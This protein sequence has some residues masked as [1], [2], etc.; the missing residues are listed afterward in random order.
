[1]TERLVSIDIA[2]AICIILVVIGHYIPDIS[3]DWYVVMLDLIYAFHMPLFIFVSGYVYWATRKKHV[4]YKNF[5]WKKF[6]RLMIPYF[7][8]S[9]VI[10]V[11]KF[12]AEKELW[13]QNPV[14]YSSL[15]KMFYLPVAGYFLWFVFALFLIFLIIPFFNTRK[16]LFILLLLS[17]MLYF[18]PLSFPKVFCLAQFKVNLLYFVFGCALVEWKINCKFV[19]ETNFLI[20]LCAFAGAYMLKTHIDVFIIKEFARIFIAF[21]G[22]AFIS[23]LSK[24]IELKVE[25]A[26][27]L[28]VNVSVYSYT[29]YLFHTT[30]EGFAKAV[31][32]KISNY[33]SESAFILTAFLVISAGMIS[34]IIMHKI[35]VRYSRLF[36]YLI[37]VKFQEKHE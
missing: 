35:I 1:M 33:N 15:Y 28:L 34:P 25:F 3:P 23:N 7:F 24:Y 26:N 29:I 13:V 22:I 32:L 27:K 12:L 31:I 18:V 11:V 37:G 9:V 30:F 21:V 16:L 10:I 36:S 8:A 19:N 20:A 14:T 2:R 4:T 5:V 17:L 6:Q